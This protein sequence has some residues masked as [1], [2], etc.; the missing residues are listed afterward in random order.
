MIQQYK[1]I[2]QFLYTPMFLSGML[3]SLYILDFFPRL[4]M[5]ADVFEN[6]GFYYS[7][8]WSMLTVV[9]LVKQRSQCL[10]YEAQ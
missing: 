6:T 9:S 5:A 8:W 3:A 1:K 10:A 2:S 7:M 4:L